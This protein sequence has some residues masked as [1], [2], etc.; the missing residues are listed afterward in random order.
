[1]LLSGSRRKVVDSVCASNKH[2]AYLNKTIVAFL[3][4]L[5]PSLP[6]PYVVNLV[7]Y[8]NQVY[9]VVKLFANFQLS[10]LQV[11]GT[12]SV[13]L[14]AL[15][16]LCQANNH[17]SECLVS[18]GVKLDESSANNACIAPNTLLCEQW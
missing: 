13:M 4:A 17:T 16:A 10:S 15:Q 3:M 18:M 5:Q 6:A 8:R 2:A 9:G 11:H 7:F 12:G 1:M 14:T